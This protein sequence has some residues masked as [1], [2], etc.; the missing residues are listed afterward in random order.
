MVRHFCASA[1]VIN[2]ENKKILLVKHKKFNKWAQPGGH[3]ED[4]EFPEETAL[5]EVYE[6]TGIKIKLLGNNFPREDDFIRPMAIQKNRGKEGHVHIDIFYHAQPVGSV[7]TVINE[8]EN[9]GV[10]WFSLEEVLAMDDVFDD[11]KISFD[12]LIRSFYSQ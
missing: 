7:E 12:Y 8:K 4:E 1:L 6:E 9:D 2:P 5:R 11:I 3:I 10:E